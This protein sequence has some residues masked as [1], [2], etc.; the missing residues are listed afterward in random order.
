MATITYGH[1][2][3]HGQRR[4]QQSSAMDL[5]RPVR[6]AGLID[7]A[8]RRLGVILLTWARRPRTDDSREQSILRAEQYRAQE[9]RERVAERSHRLMVPR[10]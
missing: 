7:R 4:P 9:A 3:G 6:R 8:A 1:Q 2:F 10:L 5:P